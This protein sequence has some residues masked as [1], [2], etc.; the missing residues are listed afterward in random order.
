MCTNHTNTN[1]DRQTDTHRQTD[2]QTET[3]KHKQTDTQT[4]RQR[5]TYR[6]TD[7]HRQTYRQTDMPK[8]QVGVQ[9]IRVHRSNAIFTV[10]VELSPEFG[11]S[12]ADFA[13][14]LDQ[15]DYVSIDH[16]YWKNTAD[17]TL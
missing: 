2:T 1:T 3:G 8:S 13:F 11:V 12:T 7:T 16:I 15:S 4:L 14:E 10:T 6:Q 5:Q 17:L 9:Q